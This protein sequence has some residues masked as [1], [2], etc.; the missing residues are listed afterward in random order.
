MA[1]SKKK[2]EVRFPRNVF[3]KGG[4]LVLCSAGEKYEYSTV[5]VENEK[6]LDIAVKEGY[7]DDFGVIMSE[8]EE[9]PEVD[10]DDF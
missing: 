2:G 9:K 10:N 1:K 8:G 5:L 4:D 3:K 7:A 6:E